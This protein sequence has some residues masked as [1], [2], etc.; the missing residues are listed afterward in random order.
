MAPLGGELVRVALKDT[1]RSHADAVFRREI[2]QDN[3]PVGSLASPIDQGRAGIV[4]RDLPLTHVRE[5]MLVPQGDII[6]SGVTDFV[7]EDRRGTVRL[8][9][10]LVEKAVRHGN[11][12]A[13]IVSGRDVRQRTKGRGMFLHGPSPHHQVQV[14]ELDHLSMQLGN[15]LHIVAGRIEIMAV[16]DGMRVQAI[17][18]SWQDDYRSL[19]TAQLLLGKR[20]R[21]IRDPIVIEQIT[22]DEQHIHFCRYGACD[23]SLKAVVIEGTVGLALFRFTVT[24]AIQMHIGCMQDF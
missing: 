23:D 18:I 7:R 20:N 19:Q 21:F 14:G 16:I 2:K 17:V 22:S 4:G 1:F 8:L 3:V 15:Y 11:V 12:P 6:P 24:V 10:G 5:H 9:A 13:L